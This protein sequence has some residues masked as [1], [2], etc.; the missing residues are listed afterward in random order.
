MTYA[1][2]GLVRICTL[3]R[4]YDYKFTWMSLNRIPSAI[5]QLEINHVALGQEQMG[6]SC[7]STNYSGSWA[8][9]CP[10]PYAYQNSGLMIRAKLPR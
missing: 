8:K 10:A 1:P 4:Y 7:L 9:L 5:K 2:L 6:N 3:P